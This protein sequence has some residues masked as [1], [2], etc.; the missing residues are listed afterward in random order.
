MVSAPDS[1]QRLPVYLETLAVTARK[2]QQHLNKSAADLGAVVEILNLVSV[3]P[4]EAK[5]E[6]MEVSYKCLFGNG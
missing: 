4:V 2:E 6:T 1:V 3:I 5:Q